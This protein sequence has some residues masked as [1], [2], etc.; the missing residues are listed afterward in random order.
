MNTLL[1]FASFG[2]AAALAGGLLFAG[3]ALTA[4]VRKMIA[5]EYVSIEPR[6]LADQVADVAR[7]CWIAKDPAFA[8]FKFDGIEQGAEATTFRVKFADK[9]KAKDAAPRY[10]RVLIGKAGSGLAVIAEQESIDLRPS[11]E[12]HINVLMKGRAVSC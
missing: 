9:P 11:I 10:F 7:R 3:P 1:R 2:I 6:A 8:G 4:P 5:M 12:D